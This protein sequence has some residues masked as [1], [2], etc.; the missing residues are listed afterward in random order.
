MK[1]VF[2]CLLLFAVL[3]SVS[4][5]ASETTPVTTAETA[6]TDP[7]PEETTAVQETEAVSEEP[8][9]FKVSSI[10]C[11]LVGDSEDIYMGLI[12]REK[13]TWESEDPN[14]ISVEN[15]VLTANSVGTTT[16]RA[17]CEDR[18][19]ECTASCLAENE[20]EL[21]G[22]PADILRKPR[23]VVPE[24][25]LTTPCTFYD[26]AALVGDSISYMLLQCENQG[27]YLGNLLFLTRGG[28]SLNGFVHRF[29]NIYFQGAPMNLEDAIAASKV[30]RMYILIGS[31][32]LACEPNRVSYLENWDTMLK[33]I[34][35]KSPEVE[36]VII[37]NI[38]QCD[39]AAADRESSVETYN[40]FV[41]EYNG[42]MEQYCRENDCMYLDLCYYIEDHLGSMPADYNL[43]GYHM[44]DEG[45][46][47]WIKVMRFYAEYELAGGKIS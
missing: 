23:R 46:M 10:T 33:W 21:K 6:E 35:E 47:N 19:L 26:H 3:L 13:L 43:D 7:V 11:S 17:S 16:I 27:N 8:M 36:I 30:D 24:V 1:K 5:C 9:F 42:K 32:D 29:K 34:R 45:Y 38:P 44:N 20:E 40:A 14:V 12:P 28:T 41:K 15:G 39:S 2:A 25:D 4:G 31:N 37:S 22:L 18:Q